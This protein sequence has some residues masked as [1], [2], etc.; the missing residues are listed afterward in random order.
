MTRLSAGVALLLSLS[1]PLQAAP[2][3][4]EAPD[5]PVAGLELVRDYTQQ[6]YRGELAQLYLLFT[7]NLRKELPMERLMLMHRQMV[8]SYG[9]ETEVVAEDSREKDGHRGF[10][11]WA[12]FDKHDG[13][14]K[15]Q[16]ILRG[17]DRISGFFIVP[18]E[19]PSEKQGSGPPR[20]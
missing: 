1:L 8:D 2:P 17:D 9:K 6:F 13:L 11:R 5:R 3:A 12:K 16:W 14:I 4:P 18:A 7:D 20:S 15:V 10:V 19:R